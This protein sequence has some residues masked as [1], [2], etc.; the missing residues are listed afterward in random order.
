M[1]EAPKDKTAN[2]K[3][4]KFPDD[5]VYYGETSFLDETGKSVYLA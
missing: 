2:M 4:F 1:V 3:A 5:T